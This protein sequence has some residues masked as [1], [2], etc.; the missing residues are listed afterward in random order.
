MAPGLTKI[1]DDTNI[2]QKEDKDN[3]N[4]EDTNKENLNKGGN[5]REAL[6]LLLIEASRHALNAEVKWKFCL[7]YQLND[8]NQKYF[9]L[10]LLVFDFI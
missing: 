10:M 1:L 6:R 4:K 2:K 3:V 7:F 9:L 8:S 5:K